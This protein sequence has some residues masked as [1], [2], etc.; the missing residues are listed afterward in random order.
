MDQP[1]KRTGWT[2]EP[3]GRMESIADGT[4]WMNRLANGGR[5]DKWTRMTIEQRMD[6]WIEGS[7]R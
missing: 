6:G 5:I 1:D 4:R 7:D 3:G 2:D